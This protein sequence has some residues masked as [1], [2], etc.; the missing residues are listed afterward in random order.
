MSER[1]QRVQKPLTQEQRAKTNERQR[2]NYAKRRHLV[3]R[4]RQADIARKEEPAV[5]IASGAR[6]TMYKAGDEPPIKDGRLY[7]MNRELM[8]AKVFPRAEAKV[9]KWRSLIGIPDVYRHPLTGEFKSLVRKRG[10]QLLSPSRPRR[11]EGERNLAFHLTYPT[12]SISTAE[13][14]TSSTAPVTELLLYGRHN[15][16]ALAGEHMSH[17]CAEPN[18]ILIQE[19]GSYDDE[20][21]E[22]DPRMTLCLDG[23]ARPEP[24]VINFERIPHIKT[25]ECSYCLRVL[26]IGKCTGHFYPSG[27]RAP[28]CME[29]E[30]PRYLTPS[31]APRL[32]RLRYDQPLDIDAARAAVATLQQSILDSTDQIALLQEI[33]DTHDYM[34]G[35]AWL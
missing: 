17:L 31:E 34:M 4:R 15:I 7:Q 16:H 8:K 1:K 19:R 23:H 3:L 5:D 29:G 2:R 32:E 11:V 13:E 20:Q 30:V 26:T 10:C 22:R 21:L 18:C 27:V 14:K 28:D 35:D 12:V 33:I 9:Q 25:E 24:P 6:I